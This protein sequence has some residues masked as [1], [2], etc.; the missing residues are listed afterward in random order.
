MIDI[1]YIAEDYRIK[2]IVC[3]YQ[4]SKKN[5]FIL[6]NFNYVIRVIR[7]QKKNDGKNKPSGK[8]PFSVFID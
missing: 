1:S 3:Q 4:I 7:G 6:F 5:I 8:G 2:K